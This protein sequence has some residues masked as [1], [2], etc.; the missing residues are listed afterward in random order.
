MKTTQLLPLVLLACALAVPPARANLLLYDG[1]ATDTDGQGRT[2]YS[3]SQTKLGNS[4]SGVAWTTGLAAGKKWS[5]TSGVVYSFP[6]AGLSLP[7]VFAEG[8][9][10]QFSARG[11]G[12]GYFSGSTPDTNFRAKN[13][14]IDSTM[15]TTGKLYYRCL[16]KMETNAYNGLKGT[17]WRY[18][19]AGISATPAANAYDNQ[20]NLKN[21]GI[22]IAFTGHDSRV[23]IYANIGGSATN[24]LANISANTTY[25]VIAE[26]DYDAGKAK[27]YASSISSYSKTFTWNVEDFAV[28]SAVTASAMQV[29][30][31]DGSYKSNDGK[32]VFDEIAVGTALSDVAVVTA[33]SAPQLGAVSLT[34]TGAAT[35]Q[36]AA[37]EAVNTADTMSWITDN[38]V[39]TPST[40]AFAT[41]VAAETTAT[42][43]ISGLTANKTWQISALAENAGGADAKVAGT[44]YTG[45]LSLGATTDANEYGLV[46]GGVTVSR[47]TADPFPLTVNYTISGSVGTE[48]TTWAAPAP[49]TIPAN[50]ASATLPVVPLMDSSI[51]ADITITVALAA[52]NYE[53]PSVSSATLTLFNLSAPAGKKTWVAAADGLASDGA[54][55]SPSGA[56]AFSDHILFDGNFS[57]ARCTWDAAATHTVASWEQTAAFTGTVELQTTYDTGAFPAIAIAGDFTV[58]GGTVTQTANSN[59]QVYR[60]SATVG[61]NLVVTAGAKITATGKG[62]SSGNFPSGSACGVHG[63]SVNDLSKVYGD[64]KHPVDIGS[65]GSSANMTGGGAV[66][67]V[68]TGAATV[69]GT[70]AAQ[71]SQGSSGNQHGAGG[72]IYLQAASV[73]GTGEITAAGYGSGGWTLRPDGAGGRIAVVLTS[74]TAL[75][76][77]AT[78]LR[79]NGT[80]AGY[81]RSSGGGTIFVKTAAQPNGTLYVVNN[82]DTFVSATYWPTKRGVTPIPE[83]QTWTL[84]EIVLRGTGVLC[85]PAGTTLEV[86]VSGVSSTSDRTGG[87]LYEGGTID[88][89]TAPYVLSGKWVFQADRPFTFNGNVT[90]SGGASI[91]CLRFSGSVIDGS[92]ENGAKS[93]DFTVCDVS[94]NGNLTIASDGYASA[95]MGGPCGNAGT[96]GRGDT[97]GFYSRHGGQYAPLS[98]NKCYGSVFD[99][100]LPGQFAQDGDHATIGVGGGALK[101]TVTGDLVVN[102]KISADGVV[103]YKSSAPAGSVNIQANTLSGAGSISATG[104]K[105][106]AVGWGDP[107]YHGVG[108]RI[109]VRV[110]GEDVGTTG[111]WAKFAARG[112]ATNQVN[113]AN[114]RNQNSSAGTI[115]LQGK[116]DGEKGGTIY[117][118]NQANYDTSNVATWIPAGARGDAAE[119]FRNASLVIADRGVVAAGANKVRFKSVSIA[120]NSK[121]DLAGQTVKTN[122]AF[123]GGDRLEPGTYAAS[124]A[125]VSAFVVD[126]GEGGL[127]IVQGDETVILFR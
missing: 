123:L 29:M 3:T 103:R 39:N 63:G 78:K 114:V 86:P 40:N 55:W 89:G 97:G 81:Q 1:F 31:I 51:T 107:S 22:R 90:V 95:E 43:T 13:R 38:G 111:I 88:F 4:N 113:T 26:L 76:F 11:G 49:V 53:I 45:D 9:G 122:K 92:N 120:A 119:D 72:S 7:S 99:P 110:T 87:I 57:N 27:I 75:D 109:A 59:S 69:N 74:A 127:F 30:F 94:V 65:G 100:V 54:N 77:P 41:A 52:G 68:V 83:G 18:Q 79:C 19:G 17:S 118:K 46:A 23:D 25:I 33:A 48:G 10:D 36:I 101:L 104:N 91:G 108:G 50:A 112:C 93:D 82:F 21:N 96:G 116:S 37:T 102:G 56:P 20:D 44:I 84:D 32:V 16:M 64:L 12:A 124:N 14:A 24:V 42:G 60:L 126:S 35:Y 80:T 105:T 28:P 66:H 73:G 2:A 117:V 34:R 62:Y 58:S 115:Y 67:L 70:V 125:A 15:P 71:P 61:G 6:G 8:S 106:D 47:A 98:G 5:D 121:L 85:V